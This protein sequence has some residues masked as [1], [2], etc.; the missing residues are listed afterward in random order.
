ME[1]MEKE[2]GDEKKEQQK[3]IQMKM[4]LLR[5]PNLHL[6]LLQ[7]LCIQ[8][9]QKIWNQ[10]IR[11][12]Q[13]LVLVRSYKAGGVG[14]RFRRNTIVVPRSVVTPITILSPVVRYTW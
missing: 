9:S 2:A 13:A 8:M 3:T 5:P 1:R 10:T 14:G 4:T 7:E 12:I 11:P 6:N